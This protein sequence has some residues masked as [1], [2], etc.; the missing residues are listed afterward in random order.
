MASGQVARGIMPSENHPSAKDVLFE[1]QQCEKIVQFRD[2]VVAGTHPRIKVPRHSP[3]K[4]SHSN[5]ASSSHPLGAPKGPKQAAGATSQRQNNS[6]PGISPHPPNTFVP[7]L[8]APSAAPQAGA[9]SARAYGSAG[10]QIDPIFLEKSDDLIR[11]EIQLQRQRLERALRE[12]VD[13]RRIA[14]KASTQLETLAEFNLHDVLAQALTLVEA[15]APLNADAN[16]LAANPEAASDSFDE[17]SYYSSQHNSPDL[18]QTSSQAGRVSDGVPISQPDQPYYPTGPRAQVAA[19]YKQQQ[20]GAIPPTSRPIATYQQQGQSTTSAPEHTFSYP[21][22]AF[23]ASTSTQ[24]RRDKQ[25][26]LDGNTTADSTSFGDGSG[27]VSRSGSG[28]MMELDEQSGRSVRNA[29][30][31]RRAEPFAPSQP[32]P[33]VVAQDTLPVAPQPFHVSSLATAGQRQ[34][35]SQSSGIIQGTTAQVTALRHVANTVSS[36]D[37]SPQGGRKGAKGKGKKKDRKNKKAG[38]QPSDVP[39]IKEEPRS[40]SPLNAPTFTRPQKRQ[41]RQ[42]EE[43]QDLHG[44]QPSRS[45][46]DDG[47][48]SHV[49]APAYPGPDDY[50]PRPA[51]YAPATSGYNYATT[52]YDQDRRVTSSVQPYPVHYGANEYYPTPAQPVAVD[53]YDRGPQRVYRDAYEVP[54]MSSR[55]E[56]SRARSRSPLVRERISPIMGP[57]RAPAARVVIDASG[58]HYYEPQP[59][60]PIVRQS[61]PPPMRMDDA[62]I[63]YERPLRA[64]SRRPVEYEE[65]GI[66]YRRASPTYVAPRRVVTQPEYATDPHRTYRQR[67]YSSRPMPPPSLEEYVPVRSGPGPGQER[68]PVEGVP[69]EYAMRATTAR[70]AE[71]VRYEMPR[72]YERVQTVRPDL[73]AHPGYPAA[74]HGGAH[75]ELMQPPPRAYSVRPAESGAARREFSARPVESYYGHPIRGDEGV[76]YVERPPGAPQDMA[77]GGEPH[78]EMYR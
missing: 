42:A 1:I 51:S 2:A 36:P 30:Q 13:Q 76:A 9:S 55:P 68:G 47:A 43:A 3:G 37:S 59:P 34:P 6:A 70:P 53:R 32:P 23:S 46:R 63:I 7:G 41:K 45:F 56:G 15:T 11:A 40:P 20:A 16:E 18:S 21:S 39:Y 27:E 66:V 54:R 52:A 26:P 38:Q 22:N 58:R 61:V 74:A 65:N 25:G 5:L 57:P 62:E 35:A 50:R 4:L 48:L 67:E 60:A 49:P 29:G 19:Q 12:E 10:A 17:N 77:Y 64:E 33:V 31:Q 44:R 72:E 73:P 75:R 24:V 71:P 69:R 28:N 8:G 78:R 14:Q